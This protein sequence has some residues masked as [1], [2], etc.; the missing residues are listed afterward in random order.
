[1]KGLSGSNPHP[2]G[3]IDIFTLAFELYT[4]PP[5]ADQLLAENLLRLQFNNVPLGISNVAPFNFSS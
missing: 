4:F 2:T 1:M 5:K 3:N